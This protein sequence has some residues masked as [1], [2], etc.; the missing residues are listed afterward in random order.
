M[1]SSGE[2][3]D[4]VNKPTGMAA[5]N[6]QR[7]SLLSNGIDEGVWDLELQTGNVYFNKGMSRLFGYS[8]FEMSNLFNWRKDCLHPADKKKIITGINRF[9]TSAES[10][11]FAEY[12]LRCRNG[13]YKQVLEKMVAI[14]NGKGKA[15]RVLGSMHDLSGI[16]G[17]KNSTDEEYLQQ[18]QAI[19]RA[20]IKAEEEERKVISDELNENINQV[21]A[22][23]NL[24]IEQ[25]KKAVPRTAAIEALGSAQQLL[26]LSIEHI[27][28]LSR[29]LTPA[30]MPY[31]GLA[32]S[33][34]ELLKSQ[35]KICGLKYLFRADKC[36][37]KKT[38]KAKKL[39]LYRIV[40][41]QLT[42]IRLHA[43]ARQVFVQL[44]CQENRIQLA[45]RDNG[46]GF[47][48]AKLK[49]GYGFSRIQRHTE[50]Y[51]GSFSVK[52]SPGKGCRVD[53]LI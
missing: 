37:E 47:D 28:A 17:L 40:Q 2:D 21:L 6:L 48:P 25:A 46:V 16:C 9:L 36:S 49:Y 32:S 12:A 34:E 51:N 14:R 44:E 3:Q 52:S 26:L 39:L 50:A 19:T 11:W 41:L 4:A 43:R 38:D 15:T 27:R 13:R 53:I 20:I 45:I 35:E 23:V 33:V 8:R 31:F 10:S 29:Q 5:E 24:H 7:H 22:T 42:N 30:G 18:Q 1:K